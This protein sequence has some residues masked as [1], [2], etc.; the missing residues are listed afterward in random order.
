MTFEEAKK[1]LEEI[2]GDRFYS[3]EYE[4]TVFSPLYENGERRIEPKCSVYISGG[5]HHSG[6]TWSEAITNL[7][8]SMSIT[9]TVDT[10]E[11]PGEEVAA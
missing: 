11:A 9:C 5:K 4:L 3:I 2:A 8:N 1:N 10:A 7:K 6:S